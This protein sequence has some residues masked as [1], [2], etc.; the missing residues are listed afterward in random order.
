DHVLGRRH[1]AAVVQ[2]RADVDGFDRVD[3]THFYMSFD[4]SVAVPVLGTVQDEDVVYYNNGT[5]SLFFDGSVNLVG[6]TDL[7]A[8]S[9][10]GGTL[11]F[12]TDNTTIPNGVG[13]SGDDADI[14][15]WNGGSSYTRVFDASTLSH[16]STTNVDGF[17]YVNATHYY[18]SFSSGTSVTGIASVQDEDVLYYNGSSW[19]VYFD[20][21][22]YISGDDVDAFDIP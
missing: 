4:G 17:V 3:A 2:P 8:I 16:W 20:G 5:W 6:S 10:V 21:T 7:D 18:I 22:P 9:V 13:G 19:S 1:L 12:S 15:R 14:Y 11:Y